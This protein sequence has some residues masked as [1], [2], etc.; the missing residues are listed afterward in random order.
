MTLWSRGDAWLR[1]MGLS[2]AL[3][4]AA[5]GSQIAATVDWAEADVAAIHRAMLDGT[6]SSQELVE[7]CRRR[8]WQHENGEAPLHAIVQLVDDALAAAAAADAHLARTGKLL[9]PLHGIPIVVKDNID[10]AGTPTTLGLLALAGAT[11]KGDAEVIARIRRAGGI[12][13]AKANLATLARS[14]RETTSEVAGRTLNPY[15]PRHTI[16]GSSGGVA[17]AVAVG[18]ATLGVGTDTGASIR[19]PAAHA[20]LTGIRPTFGRVPMSGI[21]PLFVA[22]D[23]AGPM[24]RTVADATLLLGVLAADE[25]LIAAA[26]M[27]AARHLTV[28]LGFLTCLAA[29]DRTDSMVSQSLAAALADLERLGAQVIPIDDFPAENLVPIPVDRDRF[30]ADLAAFLGT[31]ERPVDNAERLALPA[32]KPGRGAPYD[33]ALVAARTASLRGHLDDLR[34]RHDLAAFVYPTWSRAPL[35]LDSLRSPNG[36][37]SGFAAPPLGLPAITVPMG[38]TEDGL[39]LGIEFLGA[40][41]SEVRLVA[42]AQAYEGATHHRRPPPA[43]PTCKGRP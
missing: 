41:A 27:P 3:V 30:P 6:L 38:L 11:P 2:T 22:R 21:A 12:I 35:P 39:P 33:P 20:C 24:A 15:S 9:G 14:S 8:I 32:G 19:G 43:P 16:A 23:T 36:D 25:Q 4:A 10:V 37:N 31:R 28:R 18:Y 40:A 34:R 5:C 42:I 26:A 17:A 1:A 29:P 7:T 13:L